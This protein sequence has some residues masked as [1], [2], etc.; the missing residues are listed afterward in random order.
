MRHSAHHRFFCAVSAAVLFAGFLPALHADQDKQSFSGERIP[1]GLADAKQAQTP[2]AFS[3]STEHAG[4]TQS[5]VVLLC[6]VVLLGG[7]VYF[8]KN[9]RFIFQGGNKGPRKL[10]ISETRMLGGRQFLVVAEYDDRKILLGVCQGRIDYL[11]NLG[12]N[13]ETF[14]RELQEKPE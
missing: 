8:V 14:S 11:C 7:G 5:L 12:G 6:L 4:M 13:D 10:Q 3:Y 9:G 1:A 2:G